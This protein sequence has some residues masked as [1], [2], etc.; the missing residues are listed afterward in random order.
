VSRWNEA[1][2]M[3]GPLQTI[4]VTTRQRCELVD[5][6]AR[7]QEVVDAARVAEGLL[8]A[9]VQHTTAG[10][11]INENADPDVRTDLLAQLERLA[12]AAAA[13]RHAEG[14]ADAHVKASLVGASVTVPVVQGRLALGTW[15]GVYFCEFDGP[16][17]RTV[18]A[19]VIG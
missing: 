7:L 19:R 12:P 8:V 16:R 18:A 3:I 17:Q 5:I 13:Y 14:N 11:T 2:D 1:A 9:M 10:L 15:Q 6:T 4:A